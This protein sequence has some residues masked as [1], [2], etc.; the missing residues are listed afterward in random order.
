MTPSRLYYV[1]VLASLALTTPAAGQ[2]V[3][4][5]NDFEDDA[6]GTYTMSNW[7]ADWNE[8]PWENGIDEGRATVV[9]GA[10]AFEG[11]RS[12]RLLYPQGSVGAVG[13]AGGGAEW[14]MD[15]GQSYD[16]LYM[17]Y[18][19]RFGA[20]FDFVLGGKLPG[21]AGGIGNTGG[22]VPNGY[23]GWSARMMW[24]TNGSAGSNTNGDTANA[25]QYLYHPDQPGTWGENLRWDDG[26]NGQWAELESDRWYHFEHRVVMNTPGQYN[27][28]IQAWLDGE[29]V[30][31]EYG[32][33][34]RDVS[35]FGIDELL[36]STFFGGG[37]AI[38]APS[39][40]EFV[41][42]DD[43]VVSTEPIGVPEPSL[44]IGLAVGGAALILRRRRQHGR[45]GDT[46]NSDR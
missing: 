23:D 38:W 33:R 44:A 21:L 4:F 36:F 15:L 26:P 7:D 22:N 43:F 5:E 3:I 37:S 45:R 12:L 2:G 10:A 32:L 11:G 13:N 40:D 28:E 35:T 29:L 42:Y 17:G 34:F 46:S 1:C 20:G 31:E 39:Q 8:P 24:R 30:M 19:I 27:G 16:E 25:V 18:R 6:V 14:R 9:T 41:F